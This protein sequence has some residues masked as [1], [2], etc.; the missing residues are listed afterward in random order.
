MGIRYRDVGE[1][2]VPG[3]A[4]PVIIDNVSYHLAEIVV[5]KDGMID[6]WGLI[7]LPSFEEKIRSGWVRT[8]IPDGSELSAFPLGGMKVERF[9]ARRTET[10]LLQE[11]KDIIEKLNDRPDSI[12]RCHSAFT[13]YVQVPGPDSKEKLLRAYESVPRHNRQF[14]LGDMDVDDIPIRVVLFGSDEFTRSRKAQIQERTIRE[15][16]LKGLI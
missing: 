15:R 14:I 8:S 10:E 9:F 11:V 6:C 7:D 12:A 5:Y 3:I 1:V 16:Y 4:L 13:F 2:F